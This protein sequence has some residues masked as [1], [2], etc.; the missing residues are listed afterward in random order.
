MRPWA[1]TIT[2]LAMHLAVSRQYVWQ[3]LYGKTAVSETRF[4]DI[5]R[6]IDEMINVRR[7]GRTFGERLRS[8]RIAAGFTLKEVAGK[9]GYS[10][11]AVERWE[12]DSCLPKPGVLWHLRHV[13]GVGEDWMPSENLRKPA[14]L[15]GQPL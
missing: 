10:W 5:D 6:A 4:A 8:A 1:I 9:I 3:I 12:L 13:Y 2:D 7:V 11:I 15:S 14:R